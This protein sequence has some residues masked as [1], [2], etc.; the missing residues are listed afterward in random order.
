MSRLSA[1]LLALAFALPAAAEID[2]DAVPPM[3]PDVVHGVLPNG[4][5]YYIRS[6][7]KPEDRV[8]LRLAVRVGSVQEEDAERGLAH[9]AEHMNFNGSENFGPGEL[10]DYLESIG[11]RFGADS[12][13]YTSFD[14]TVYFLEVPTDKEGAYEKGLT[15][16]ADWAGRATLAAEEIDKER[17][18]V[19]DELRGRKGARARIRDVQLPIQWRGSKY[20]ER[21]PI[22]TEE[23]ILGAP[24][25][26]VRGFYHRWYRP[27]NV[28]LAVVGTID[29]AQ[30]EKDVKRIFGA[31]PTS[32][33]RIP[34]PTYEV[35]GHEETLYSIEADPELTSS[36]V[37]VYYKHPDGPSRTAG[38]AREDLVDALAGYLLSL[39]LSER[40]QSA[41]PPFLRAGA[42]MGGG[43]K[44]AKAF[45]LSA[46]ARD[47]EIPTA[48]AALMEELQRA[49]SFGFLEP[50]LERVKA[51]VLVSS[52]SA[53]KE[54]DQRR[55][56]QLASQAVR[57]FLD[58]EPL[59]SAEHD[60][61]FAQA[62]VPGIGLEEVNASLR[63]HTEPSS[64]VV[65]VQ[66]PEKEGA[67]PTLE[68]LKAAI[69]SAAG[70]EVEAYVDAVAGRQLMEEAP[71][72]GRILSRHAI[73][74]LGVVEVVLSN[75][76]TVIVKET[77]FRNDE[78]RLTGFK[79]DGVAWMP[80]EDQPAAWRSDRVAG[81]SGLG[82]FTAPE[83]RKL[84][85]DKLAGA[86]VNIGRF[87][88][89]ASGNATPADVETM[90]QLLHLRFTAPAFRED[91]FERVIDRE[92]ESLRNQLNSPQG[93]YS[94]AWNEVAHDGH[95]MFRPTTMEELDRLELA[96]MARTY[97]QLF[98]DASGWTFVIVGNFDADEHAGLLE[99][100]LASLPS[101]RK[102]EPRALASRHRPDYGD[103]RVAMPLG[104]TTR[105]VAKGIE[106]QA[107][108]SFMIWAPTGLDP[109]ET[110]HLGYVT[111]LLNI[112]LRE[113]LREERGDTYGVGVGAS[114]LSP[115]PDYG[116]VTVSWGSSPAARTS[117]VSDVLDEIRRLRRELPSEDEMSKLREMRLSS[118]EEGL[119]E[120]G[121]WLSVLS[122]YY[123]HDRDPR[124][125]LGARDRIRGMSA[126]TLRATARRYLD[127]SRT[128]EVYLVP[129]G[130][131]QDAWMARGEQREAAARLGQ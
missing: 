129:E 78:I 88:L 72:P 115:Y 14:E 62:I 112:R 33:E 4:L 44:T 13:A 124:R 113:R 101:S 22:G 50:E 31:L 30:V 6:N 114:S 29:P 47:G 91:A 126:R 40:A 105:M 32:A 120:N 68:E 74:E 121:W 82:E 70:K 23:V 108:T 128:A 71:A 109:D 83:L 76:V 87:T 53:Y 46:R 73:P 11:A 2:L 17:G 123:T 20:A 25:D 54:R 86:G 118:L 56:G 107:R 49:R 61:E 92:A 111:D 63:R 51:L 100:Y 94:R 117:M 21:L 98:A 48:A 110:S 77:D 106:D 130:W 97:R 59:T 99:T 116:R 103:L 84:L 9:F 45:S 85:T 1:L 27:E 95:P 119:E 90:F 26:T 43:F 35:P 125:L 37:A 38:E 24:H 96:D 75:D 65:L 52:E 36:S 5:T 42:G 79:H 69:E 7:A 39:R 102:G 60:H 81:E 15:I 10:V 28:A 104:K 67:V 34:V 122:Y 18:V 55:S 57:S 16:M 89:S 127:L 12:N 3:D 64:R 19:A 93:V 80:A 58:E 66:A 41:D 131:A 8:E